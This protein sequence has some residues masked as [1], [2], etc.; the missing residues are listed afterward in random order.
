MALFFYTQIHSIDRVRTSIEDFVR[1]GEGGMKT[2]WFSTNTHLYNTILYYN[3]NN[4]K[5]YLL[6]SLSL[7]DQDEDE[8][9][10]QDE[11]QDQDQDQDQNQRNQGLRSRSTKAPLFNLS[12]LSSTDIPHS[13]IQPSKLQ[14]VEFLLP[15]HDRVQIPELPPRLSITGTGL[16]C[17]CETLPIYLYSFYN[18][19]ISLGPFD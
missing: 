12:P 10:D 5:I 11:D 15:L 8:D 3:T 2:S 18:L 17:H 13:S 9:E 19:E 6:L 16:P 4:R 7:K 1:E 14:L